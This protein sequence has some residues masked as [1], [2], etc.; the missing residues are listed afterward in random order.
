MKTVY[1]PPITCQGSKGFEVNKLPGYTK[2]KV[3]HD[4]LLDNLHVFEGV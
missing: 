3:P 2:V 1:S 4:F